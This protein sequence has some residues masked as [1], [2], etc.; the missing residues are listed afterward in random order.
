MTPNG[1]N[2]PQQDPSSNHASIATGGELS[3]APF[4]ERAREAVIKGYKIIKVPDYF[5]NEWLPLLGPSRWLAVLAFRQVAFVHKCKEKT[6]LRPTR[7]TFRELAIW[8]GQSRPQMH[9]LL[10]K[11]GLLTWFVEPAE[12]EFG[13]HPRS[14]SERRTYLVRVEIPLTPSDQ[15]KLESFLQANRPSDDEGWL[16][17]LHRALSAKHSEPP[18]KD[19]LPER[20]K[21]IQQ[22]VRELRDPSQ[23]LPEDIDWACDELLERWQTQNFGQVTHYFVRKWLP[24]LTPG[25]GCLLIWSRRHANKQPD[26]QIGRLHNIGW[27]DLA[28]AVGVTTKSVRRWFSD[29]ETYP[30]TRTFMEPIPVHVGAGVVD[31]IAPD[32]LD[33]AG[34]HVAVTA[35]TVIKHPIRSGDFIRLTAERR[36]G[37]LQALSLE[38]ANEADLDPGFSPAHMTFDVKLTE[39]IHPDDQALYRSLLDSQTSLA[40]KDQMLLPNVQLP[41]SSKQSSSSEGGAKVDKPGTIMERESP[42]PADHIPEV[43]MAGAEVD[44]PQ[45]VV[46]SGRPELDMRGPEI[47]NEPTGVDALRDI[48]RV[49]KTPPR[50]DTEEQLPDSPNLAANSTSQE[51]PAPDVVVASHNLWDIRHILTEAAIPKRDKDAI[52]AS[53]TRRWQPFVAWLLWSIATKSID[54][55][56]LHA[57]SRFKKGETPPQEF[58]GLATI[59]PSTLAAWL[60]PDGIDWPYEFDDAIRKLRSNGAYRKLRNLGSIPD[61][62]TREDDL[63]WR[64]EPSREGQRD[65]GDARVEMVVDDRGMTA[66]A[67]WRAAKAQLQTEVPRATYDTWVRDIQFVGFRDDVF[68]LGVQN[69]YAREWLE[70][71]L[72]STITRVLAGVVGRRVGVRF[73]VHE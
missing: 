72:A 15:A 21:T 6:G 3:L 8:S 13:T 46:N 61:H 67:A 20:P 34:E 17:V 71:R 50:N 47:D 1:R 39:P 37:S 24:D 69:S 9:K 27:Q 40:D 5:L 49:S 55:P 38:L 73:V 18:S 48:S 51:M 30:H 4:T 68:E 16:E 22:L 60:R 42:N 44:N 56:V 65:S 53:W 31:R 66:E 10:K 64:A 14:R 19:P 33:V 57:V 70:D 62:E 11:P 25:L 54:A 28:R 23:P 52:L 36:D 43:D 29:H 41:R 7:T 63:G 59:P 45:P 2:S 26:M 35:S 12:G 58:L 32:G